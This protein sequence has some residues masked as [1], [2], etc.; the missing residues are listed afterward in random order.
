MSLAQI[1]PMDSVN[2]LLAAGHILTAAHT[3]EDGL[4]TGAVAELS[5]APDPSGSYFMHIEGVTR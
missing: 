3:W 1:D 4:H 2:S 5:K